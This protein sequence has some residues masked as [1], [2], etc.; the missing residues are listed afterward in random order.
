MLSIDSMD[1]M[2]SV[3]FTPSITIYHKDGFRFLIPKPKLGRPR[4]V[5]AIQLDNY[6]TAIDPSPS[7]LA[8][9]YI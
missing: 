1:L 7:I 4:H 6:V 3:I 5:K 8:I 9:S 2:E